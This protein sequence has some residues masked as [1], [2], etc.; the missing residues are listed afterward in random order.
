MSTK[1]TYHTVVQSRSI[2]YRQRGTISVVVQQ[3][4]SQ[5]HKNNWRPSR[6]VTV[7]CA[8]W[9]KP[10]VAGILKTEEYKLVVAQIQNSKYNL[11]S[12]LEITIR[13]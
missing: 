7:Q 11:T 2:P 1:V 6:P 3:A 8:H 10:L 9:S 13:F 12:T 5:Y 4:H